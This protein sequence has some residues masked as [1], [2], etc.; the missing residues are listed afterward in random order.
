MLKGRA[1]R[2]WDDVEERLLA[3]AVK[4]FGIKVG[5]VAVES[6]QRSVDALVP[7]CRRLPGN[8]LRLPCH[9]ILTICAAAELGKNCV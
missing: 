1:Y 3:E 9:V 8:R 7:D 2:R 5:G 4:T 6:G